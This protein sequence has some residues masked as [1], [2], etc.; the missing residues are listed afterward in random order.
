VSEYN[1]PNDSTDPAAA[2]QEADL[3]GTFGVAGVR[4]AA[5][6]GS[7]VQDDKTTHRPVYGAFSMFRNYDGAGGRFGDVS[8]GAQSAYGS[9]HAYAS[10]DSRTNPTKLWIMLVNRGTSAQ[11][12][13]TIAIKNFAAAATAK[14]YQSVNG[15]APAAAAGATVSNGSISGLSIAANTIMLIAVTR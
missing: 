15:A 13:M 9:V 8:V 7:L 14:V 2:V 11:D 1:V 3:L 6:W 12:N 5:Y 4:V 10:T